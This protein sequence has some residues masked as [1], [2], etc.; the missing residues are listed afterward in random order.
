MLV[1]CSLLFLLLMWIQLL[2]LPS[3]VISGCVSLQ[4]IWALRG[5]VDPQSAR[6][7]PHLP[8]GGPRLFGE[9]REGI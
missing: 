5:L 2:G 7:H 8:L 4:T 3:H 9:I 1:T 6:F